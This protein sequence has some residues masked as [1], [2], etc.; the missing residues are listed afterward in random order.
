MACF[1]FGASCMI[2]AARVSSDLSYIGFGPLPNSPPSSSLSV[3][4]LSI[5]SSLSASL[6]GWLP[7]G[8][9]GRPARAGFC[10]SGCGL[11]RHSWSH[12][13]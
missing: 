9:W 4:S 7:P 2:I 10:T 3:S 13:S 1:S 8:G 5:S 6:I 11:S 12:R